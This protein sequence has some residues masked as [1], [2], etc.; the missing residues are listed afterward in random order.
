MIMLPYAHTNEHHAVDKKY[1]YWLHPDTNKKID[2]I[3]TGC[4]GGSENLDIIHFTY[5]ASRLDIRMS[6]KFI[7]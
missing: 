5:D 6:M 1:Q 2:T 4:Q 7:L 3:I